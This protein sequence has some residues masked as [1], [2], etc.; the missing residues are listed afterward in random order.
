MR[1]LWRVGRALTLTLAVA[2]STVAQGTGVW[3]EG[4]VVRW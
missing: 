1:R 3:W 2:V 4:E